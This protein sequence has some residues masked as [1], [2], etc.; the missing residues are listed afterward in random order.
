MKV[1]VNSKKLLK[2]KEFGLAK[3]E[4]IASYAPA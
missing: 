1:I 2:S 4:K 3:L